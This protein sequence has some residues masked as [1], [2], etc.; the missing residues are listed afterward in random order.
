MIDSLRFFC[1]RA[2]S[3]LVHTNNESDGLWYINWKF[4]PSPSDRFHFFLWL[5][6]I[7]FMSGTAEIK[8]QGMTHQ[9]LPLVDPIP[10]F[11]L[12]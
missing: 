4:E 8:V 2:E 5:K 11:G 3:H 12:Y 6:D 1:A 7:K 10:K 9:R